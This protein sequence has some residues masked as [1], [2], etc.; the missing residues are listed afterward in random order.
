MP[1]NAEAELS[2]ADQLPRERELRSA[3]I[4]PPLHNHT[5]HTQAPHLFIICV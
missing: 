2:F 1:C 3:F 5:I 4:S